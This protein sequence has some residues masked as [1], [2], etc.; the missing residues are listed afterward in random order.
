[1][2]TERRAEMKETEWSAL[3]VDTPYG[4]TV[5][6]GNEAQV[7]ALRI[8]KLKAWAEENGEDFDPEEFKTEADWLEHVKDR[9]DEDGT[10]I[11]TTPWVY[12]LD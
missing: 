12:M 7:E 4:E 5:F 8:E 9:S 3:V 1:M 11:Y 6:L 10:H 2:D